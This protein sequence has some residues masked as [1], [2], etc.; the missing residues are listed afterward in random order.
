MRCLTSLHA[1]ECYTSVL[2]LLLRHTVPARP[3]I[4]MRKTLAF[5]FGLA[6]GLMIYLITAM[7]FLATGNVP[8]W[9]AALIVVIGGLICSTIMLRGTKWPLQVV[10]RG[11]VIGGVL[12]LLMIPATTVLAAK[13]ASEVVNSGASGTEQAG[14]LIGSGLIAMLEVGISIAMIAICVVTYVI[15]RLLLRAQGKK[16]TRRKRSP[17]T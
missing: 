10:A 16:P 3:P 1:V 13:G 6:G 14:A 4:T 8:P 17:R 9:F 5:L 2:Q 12:W 11:S 7:V 15:A